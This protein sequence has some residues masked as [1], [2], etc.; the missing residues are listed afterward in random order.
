MSTFTDKDFDYNMKEIDGDLKSGKIDKA[1]A[2]R[3]RDK[4]INAY[5][6]GSNQKMADQVNDIR[7]ARR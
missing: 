2:K 5:K 4:I 6:T 1:E 3:I 7:K